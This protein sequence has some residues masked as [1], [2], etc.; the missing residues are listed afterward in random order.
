MYKTRYLLEKLDAFTVSIKDRL[1]PEDLQMLKDIRVG[2]EQ[3]QNEKE[4]EEYFF[5][6]LNLML[7][8]KDYFDNL[9]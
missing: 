5:S 9:S 3:S 2:I 8:L 7:M 1:T 4:V 6:L